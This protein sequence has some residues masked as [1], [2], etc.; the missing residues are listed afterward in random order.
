M[1]H[2]PAGLHTGSTFVSLTRCNAKLD[3]ASATPDCL[4]SLP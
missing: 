1:A 4:S 2:R 3:F